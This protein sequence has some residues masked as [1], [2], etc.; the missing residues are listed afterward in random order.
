MLK[1]H[2]IFHARSQK[3]ID[4]AYLFAK[5][6]HEGQF[7][8]YTNEPYIRHPVSVANLVATVTIDCEMIC[9]ALL[10]DVIEDTD[11][12]YSDLLDA[13]FGYGIAELVMQ[14]TDVSKP[15]DGNRAARKLIDRQHTCEATPRA[16]TVK[17]ADLIDNSYSIVL[18][19]PNFSVVYMRE[20][21]ALLECLREGDAT[22]YEKAV[23]QVNGYY[24]EVHMKQTE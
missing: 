24:K 1:E 2:G 13:G 19:D 11:A 16:K 3:L 12:E 15:E 8:K 4:A 20:K 17:L 9:A 6:A 18:H 5:D 22:L 7:R 21:E 23:R 10:H 14:L